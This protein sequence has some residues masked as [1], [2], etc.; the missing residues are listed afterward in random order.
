MRY[1]SI[2]LPISILLIIGLVAY[3]F[4]PTT[5]VDPNI[6]IELSLSIGNEKNP[7]ARYNYEKQRLVNPGTDEIP[8]GIYRREQ[9]FADGLPTS[10]II[11]A[12]KGEQWEQR[13]PFNIGGRTRALAIDVLDS[14]HIL[15]GGVSGGMYYT[16]NGGISWA[17]STG[18]SQL[19]SVTSIVQD[20]REGKENIWYYSTGEVYGNSADYPGDGVFKS[21]DNGKSWTALQA[22]DKPQEFRLLNNSW[23]IVLDHTRN[24]SDIL[25]L[26]SR[27]AILRSN[28]GGLNWNIVL[29]SD[30]PPQLYRSGVEVGISPSGV[31]YASL[32]SNIREDRGVWRSEDGLNWTNIL[33]LQWVT[34]YGRIVFDIF[35]KNENILYLLAHTPNQGKEGVSSAGSLERNSLW[36][37]E[38]LSGDGADSNGV[39]T[40]LSDNIPALRQDEGLIWGD[41]IAQGGYNLL[42]KIHPESEDSII[43]GGTNL[44]S[45]KSGFRNDSTTAWLGGYLKT[46]NRFEGFLNGLVYPNHHP[47]QHQLIFAD[48]YPNIAFSAHD[49]GLSK[50]T[51]VWADE[52]EWENI[53]RGYFT[54]Q[55]Y[56]IAVN[57]NPNP[58]HDMSAVILGGFQ[59]NETQYVRE[60]DPTTADWKRIGCCDGTYAGI[61]DTD[62]Y[63]WVINSRQEGTLFLQRFDENGERTGGARIDPDGGANY[64]FVN[65]YVHDPVDT[66]RIYLAGGNFLWKNKNVTA[67]TLDDFNQ[68]ETINWV[69]MRTA[70]TGVNS[71]ISALDAS[72][73]KEGVVYFG[74]TTGELYRVNNAHLD[75]YEVIELTEGGKPLDGNG[76]ISSVSI[77]PNNPE[78]V[79]VSFSNYERKSIY[80]TEDGG[81]SWRDVSGNLEEN[82]DGSGAGTSVQV[83]KIIRDAEN[84]VVYLAGTHTGLYATRG[85]P[86]TATVWVR[87]GETQIGRCP[88]RDID[89]RPKDGFLI[90]G[91]HG[92]GSFSTH[93]DEIASAAIPN[94]ETIKLYPNPTSELIHLELGKPN[95]QNWV[96]YS[97][98][99]KRVL[100]GNVNSSRLSINAKVL[101][102]GTYIIEIL[103]GNQNS[104]KKRFIKR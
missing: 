41:F 95:Y 11:R 33:P 20:T 63:T 103:D 65:P 53:N 39:W 30:Q 25:F 38:Y 89:Y 5:P 43:I 47:D 97:L 1:L 59:D 48:N 29:G 22:I 92:C 36:R 12:K 72:A 50:T 78:A 57:Q 79:L 8:E 28:D 86:G 42:V 66:R 90:V 62:D 14:N 51:D 16:V 85:L 104:V 13:G 24:D 10:S 40:D 54:T 19:K 23:R 32:S 76:Y 80:Y 67:I 52:V 96:V 84:Q 7:M 82:K 88:I 35:E 60:N 71:Y 74:T 9:A 17:R 55:F 69:R 45:S 68:T 73:K 21:T 77:D 61:F 87:E 75:E 26:A 49:G 37:Y 98:N 46:D 81:Q 44:Y 64:L 94:S 99:G 70:R 6:P 15:A 31:L 102:A 91:S 101:P 93:I 27:S 2:T 83:V 58:D 56:T 18:A 34:T 4:Y 3:H 100:N